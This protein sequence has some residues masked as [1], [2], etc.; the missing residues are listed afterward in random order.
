MNIPSIQDSLNWSKI[1]NVRR[2]DIITIVKAEIYNSFQDVVSFDSKKSN[3]YFFSFFFP[4]FFFI[5][6]LI[7]IYLNRYSSLKWNNVKQQLKFKA[8]NIPQHKIFFN[9]TRNELHLVDYIQKWFGFKS[10]VYLSMNL[11][12]KSKW[13]II[14]INFNSKI[15]K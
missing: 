7:L 9:R 5:V 8:M 2:S 11:H 6:I 15:K 13:K 1:K 4:F 12:S 14:Q 10:N 3:V